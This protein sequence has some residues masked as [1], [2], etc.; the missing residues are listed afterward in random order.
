MKHETL[1][2]LAKKY[3]KTPAQICMK[4]VVQRGCILAVGELCWVISVMVC[5]AC[6]VCSLRST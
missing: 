2:A 3:Q 5:W 6:G 1:Q 4:W